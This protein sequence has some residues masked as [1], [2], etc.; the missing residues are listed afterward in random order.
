MLDIRLL[1]LETPEDRY[2]PSFAIRAAE[3]AVYPLLR[4]ARARPVAHAELL[5]V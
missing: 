5:P 1:L 4:S 2:E 3:R